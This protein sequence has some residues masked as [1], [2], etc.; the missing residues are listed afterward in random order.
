MSIVIDRNLRQ[1]NFL[2]MK[3]LEVEV[4]EMLF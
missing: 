4:E 2:K 3:K 1:F